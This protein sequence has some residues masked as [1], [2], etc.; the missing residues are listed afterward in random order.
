MNGSCH[1]PI[2]LHSPV[3][4]EVVMRGY[5]KRYILLLY[6]N[7]SNPHF[8]S[9]PKIQHF[10]SAGSHT[11]LNFGL[12]QCGNDTWQN[13]SKFYFVVSNQTTPFGRSRHSKPF[14]QHNTP[15]FH[16]QKKTFNS[17]YYNKPSMVFNITCVTISLT[18]W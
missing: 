11:G 3:K 10:L 1:H 16:P 4:N 12:D 9:P 13:Y 2:T 8:S 6:I 18:L 14:H 7:F 5:S 17:F 15:I